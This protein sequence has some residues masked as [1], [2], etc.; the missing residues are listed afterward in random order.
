MKRR[1]KRKGQQFPGKSQ[2][3]KTNGKIRGPGPCTGGNPTEATYA[4]VKGKVE[5]GKSGEKPGVG[6]VPFLHRNNGMETEFR[7]SEIRRL[8]RGQARKPTVRGSTGHFSDGRGKGEKHPG[9]TKRGAEARETIGK[10]SE[11]K[12]TLFCKEGLV[13]QG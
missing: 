3:E 4:R 6:S 7:E 13:K 5:K 1:K 12:K 11:G 8:G 10:K 9:R 2:M